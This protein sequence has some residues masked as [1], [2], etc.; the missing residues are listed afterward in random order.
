MKAANRDL[1]AALHL[2]RD[3][4]Q[5]GELQRLMETLRTFEDT[6]YV[7][8]GSTQGGSI[9]AMRILRES[10]RGRRATVMLSLRFSDG[11]SRFERSKL[12]RTQQRWLIDVIEVLENNEMQRTK[13]ARVRSR[14]LRR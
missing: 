2:V 8:K 14:G 7:W 3:A 11:R 6:H 12:V 13:S 5:R 10:V 4:R 1:R 9:V